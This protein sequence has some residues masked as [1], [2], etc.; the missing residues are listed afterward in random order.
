MTLEWVK[1]KAL[2]EQIQWTPKNA[3]E[4]KFVPDAHDPTKRHAPIMF[5]TDIALKV[6]SKYREIVQRFLNNSEEFDLA[7]AKAWFKLTHRDMGPRAHLLGSNV[8]EAQIWQDPIPAVDYPLVDAEDINKL[9]ATILASGLTVPQLVRTAWGSAASF[10]DTD[11]RGGANGA[12]IRLAPEK[13][14][15]CQQ[16]S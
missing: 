5:T 12:S 4:V 3:N 10:R 2:P 9:K 16:S 8:P 7:F 15:A 1:T 11:F 6:D 14:L 13:R